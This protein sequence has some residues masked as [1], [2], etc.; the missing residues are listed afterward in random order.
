MILDF[1]MFNVTIFGIFT[2]NSMCSFCE[3]L[4]KQ[5]KPVLL[6]IIWHTSFVVDYY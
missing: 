5:I 1:E 3:T 4:V 6:P 2:N